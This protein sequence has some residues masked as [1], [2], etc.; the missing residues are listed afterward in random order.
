MLV[1]FECPE[2]K[3]HICER[4]AVN[5]SNLGIRLMY[6]HII[7][8]PGMAFNELVLGQRIPQQL[9]VCKSCTSPLIDRGY[10]HCPSC[11]VFHAGRIWS[12][13][14]AFG[15]WL[16]YVCPS[17]GAGIPCLWNITSC[18]I[19]AVTAPIWY[20]PV[21]R[22]KRTWVERQHKR[23]GQAKSDYIGK[24]DTP[25]PINYKRLGFLF[26]LMM[27]VG[28]TLLL[29]PISLMAMGKF[30][31]YNLIA[32][33]MI[34]LFPNLVMCG[35]GGLGFGFVMRLMMQKKGD[36]AMHLTIDSVGRVGVAGQP[37]DATSQIESIE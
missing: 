27:F 34:S 36:P 15:H 12:H 26:G 23:I 28:L 9:F 24:S 14:N 29:P 19:L 3:G 5:G 10:V 2:C 33:T 1:E 20:L 18:I 25:D 8:N 6:W 31:S 22:L 37:N 16:G 13:K 7:L 30:T 32:M 4:W 17:C 21:K 11:D 35:I